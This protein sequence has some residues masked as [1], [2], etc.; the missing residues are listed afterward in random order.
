MDK[1]QRYLWSGIF[2]TADIPVTF[3]LQNRYEHISYK[4]LEAWP[5]LR[6]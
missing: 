2:Y 1:N 6:S 4:S 5:M 3:D